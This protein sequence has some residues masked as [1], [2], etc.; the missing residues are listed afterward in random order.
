MYNSICNMITEMRGLSDKQQITDIIKVY[1]VFMSN[2]E[3]TVQVKE[4]GKNKL[5]RKLR[6]IYILNNN[7]CEEIEKQIQKEKQE[8]YIKDDDYR[9]KRFDEAASDLAIRFMN[10]MQNKNELDRQ[11]EIE[12]YLQSN[13]GCRA[14]IKAYKLLKLQGIEISPVIIEMAEKK[15]KTVN[16][17]EFE[18]EKRNNIKLLEENK[19]KSIFICNKL[20]KV[21]KKNGVEVA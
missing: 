8:G 19:S 16:E 14:I 11:I 15:G 6:A 12:Y 4:E 21:L 2:E 7:S 10:S 9:A 13:T 3:V 20:F 18:K 5:L 17:I 1:R